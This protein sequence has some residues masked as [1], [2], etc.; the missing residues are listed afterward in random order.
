MSTRDPALRRHSG[1][2]R[3][4]YFAAGIV[5]AL[6]GVG[7]AWVVQRHISGPTVEAEGDVTVSPA[8][9]TS[10]P[11]D[12]TPQAMLA[13]LAA[14]TESTMR[15]SR[16][17]LLGSRDPTGPSCVTVVKTGDLKGERPNTMGDWNGGPGTTMAMLY[18]FDRQGCKSPQVDLAW[19]QNRLKTYLE[20]E[21]ET[22]KPAAELA[23]ELAEKSRQFW[24]LT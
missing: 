7:A 6:A 11:S 19:H 18:S 3:L 16:P 4:W 1:R 12:D 22:N 10:K 23:H 5:V 24:E 9:E 2:V 13:K 14:L 17:V 15:L 8:K 20:N 21:I